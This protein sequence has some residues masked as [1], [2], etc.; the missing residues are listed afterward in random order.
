MPVISLQTDT[1]M[2]DQP[3]ADSGKSPV[4]DR[5]FRAAMLETSSINTD[6]PIETEQGLSPSLPQTTRPDEALTLVS[7]DGALL[8]MIETDPPADKTGTPLSQNES[9]PDTII[10]PL[11]PEGL[12]GTGQTAPIAVA[13]H[14]VSPER[15]GSTAPAM[16]PPSTPAIHTGTDKA[17]NMVE[18][19]SDATPTEET[20]IKIET[21]NEGESPRKGE[22]NTPIAPTTGKDSSTIPLMQSPMREASSAPAIMSDAPITPNLASAAMFQAISPSLLDHSGAVRPLLTL[23]MQEPAQA[24]NALARI[25]MTQSGMG[26]RVSVQLDPPELGRLNLDFIFDGNR[27]QAVHVISDTP[28]MQQFLKRQGALLSQIL[29]DSGF[30]DA[31]LSF[32]NQRQNHNPFMDR[33]EKTLLAHTPSPDGD[34]INMAMA[35]GTS[36]A[37]NHHLLSLD[38]LDIRA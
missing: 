22:G 31:S 36:T 6:Q 12:L 1:A 33:N 5:K 11:R 35:D 15:P 2:S 14:K 37:R 16:S 24:A 30:G 7:N 21:R 18:G 8:G 28:E 17:E 19:N 20:P 3:K 26:D 23:S 38:H 29:T 10:N 34:I 13:T 32:E 4:S 27:L 9:P 25:I